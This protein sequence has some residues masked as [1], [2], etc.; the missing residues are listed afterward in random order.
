MTKNLSWSGTLNLVAKFLP[1]LVPNIPLCHFLQDSQRWHIWLWMAALGW[2]SHSL[3]CKLFGPACLPTSPFPWAAG[4]PSDC[5][6]GFCPS[7]VLALTSRPCFLTVS[8]ML[9]FVTLWVP[10]LEWFWND[11]QKALRK[12]YLH[13]V[14][15][16]INNLRNQR[17]KMAQLCPCSQRSCWVWVTF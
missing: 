2:K 14:A 10:A 9:S 13:C 11:I 17:N 8:G 4:I 7:V 5:L 16:H 3:L 1:V 15:H 6:A 12:L